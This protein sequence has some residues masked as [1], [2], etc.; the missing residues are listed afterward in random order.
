MMVIKSE[1]V[2]KM[3]TRID[4]QPTD[5]QQSLI[6]LLPIT[7]TSHYTVY[8][9]SKTVFCRFCELFNPCLTEFDRVHGLT[10]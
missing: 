9:L 1:K 5:N 3:D 10:V 7:K 8:T 6:I 4:V 2:H